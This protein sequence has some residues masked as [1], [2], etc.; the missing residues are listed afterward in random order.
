MTEIFF[1]SNNLF[2]ISDEIDWE[3]MLCMKKVMFTFQWINT[4]LWSMPL[5]ETHAP[6][7]KLSKKELKDLTKSWIAHGL[8]NSI[9]KKITI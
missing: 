6:L 7:K 1:E 3:Q 8:Q 4:C 9:K 5:L 2:L